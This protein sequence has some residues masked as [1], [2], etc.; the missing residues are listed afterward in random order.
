MFYSNS[1]KTEKILVDEGGLNFKGSFSA[2][3]NKKRD[4]PVFW[5]WKYETGDTPKKIAEND[6]ID[7][8]FGGKTMS[9]HIETT[10]K[11]IIE[12]ST[13]KYGV[14]FYANGGAFSESEN[15]GIKN[16]QVINGEPSG[17]LPI[18]TRNGYKFAGWATIEAVSEFE[19]I[20][21]RVNQAKNMTGIIEFE[22]YV[23]STDDIFIAFNTSTGYGMLNV[24][25]FFV[26]VP[27]NLIVENNINLY[28][29][30]IEM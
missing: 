28:A 14:T 22:Y 12:K 18:P 11:Q 10:G 8:S 3:D 2:E 19:D 16:L 27:T 7:T 29:L 30:W 6:V 13:T 17:E 21:H 25:D 24:K 1:E 9:M 23:D 4:I 5:E 15:T 20:L 26:G